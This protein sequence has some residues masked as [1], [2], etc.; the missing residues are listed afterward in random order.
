MFLNKLSDGTGLSSNHFFVAASVL[1][2]P[3]TDFFTVVLRR[4]YMPFALRNCVLVPIPKPYKDPSVSDSYRSIALAPNLSKVL[5]K[6][7]L[8]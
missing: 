2:A 4:G 8:F 3:F 6:C 5:E 1:A 7:I